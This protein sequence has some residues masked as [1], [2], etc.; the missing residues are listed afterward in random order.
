MKKKIHIASR[1]MG[2]IDKDGVITDYRFISYDLVT[3]PKRRFIRRVFDF[4]KRLWRFI[5]PNGR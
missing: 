2:N 3:P 4:F 1:G 5:K